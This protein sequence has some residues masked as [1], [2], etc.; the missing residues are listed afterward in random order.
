M[1]G[2][3]EGGNEPPGSIKASNS[4]AV[5]DPRVTMDKLKQKLEAIATSS[6]LQPYQKFLI[7][8]TFICPSLIYT[9][10]TT[11]MKRISS[12][13]LSDAD[14]LI[15]TTV[16]DIL[17]LPSD[18]PDNM[19]YSPKKYKGLGLYK[20]SWEAFLQFIN[21]CKLLAKTNNIYV[22]NIRDLT[23]EIQPSLDKLGL[24]NIDFSD[25]IN[26]GVDRVPQRSGRTRKR[27]TQRRRLRPLGSGEDRHK[28]ND[29]T[30]F[31]GREGEVM[32]LRLRGEI[33]RSREAPSSGYL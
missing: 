15:R 24:A 31:R 12:K 3:C 11:P 7:I 13:F 30:L 18:T 19:L 2:L 25:Q 20:A 10:Q 21:A 27:A 9:F 6:L 33:Q 4:T 22:S 28:G 32:R 26:S 1:A 29:G 17:N 5:F 8:S 16:K 14:I 23:K